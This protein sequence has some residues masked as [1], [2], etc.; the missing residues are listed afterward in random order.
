[1][2]VPHERFSVNGPEG[3]MKYIQRSGPI[4]FGIG[5]LSAIVMVLNTIV[6]EPYIL[7]NLFD[8]NVSNIGLGRN[9]IL[10]GQRQPSQQNLHRVKVPLHER[11][12]CS[13]TFSLEIFIILTVHLENRTPYIAKYCVRNIYFPEGK[14][15]HKFDGQPKTIGLCIRKFI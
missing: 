5:F 11:H 10:T 6:P 8:P 2:N 12:S 3:P 7:L 13:P 4:V 15:Y 1:M 9:L 14:E